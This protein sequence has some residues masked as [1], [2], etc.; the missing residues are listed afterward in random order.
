MAAYLEG[1]S[2]LKT[3]F[4]LL[5]PV[6]RT[7]SIVLWLKVNLYGLTVLYGDLL[8]FRFA[9]QTEL[10]V[11]TLTIVLENYLNN[12]AGFAD[13]LKPI[14]INNLDKYQLLQSFKISE[15]QSLAQ[16]YSLADL[17]DDRLLPGEIE[18]PTSYLIFEGG[19]ASKDYEVSV[20]NTFTGNTA[21]LTLLESLLNKYKTAGKSYYI[22]IR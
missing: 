18:L 15:G 2:A 22:T 9:K 19:L 7:R 13:N 20:P 6:L 3:I 16:G 10:K 11:N 1:W 21:A 12:H 17:D 5:P 8:A 14:Y 4:E